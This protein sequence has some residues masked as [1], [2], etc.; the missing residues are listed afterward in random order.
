MAVLCGQVVFGRAVLASCEAGY[1]RV[2]RCMS[3]VTTKNTESWYKTK[4]DVKDQRRKPR[5]ATKEVSILRDPGVVSLHNL[6]GDKLCELLTENVVYADGP[7]V[8][9]NKPQGLPITG[10]PE[11]VSVSSLLPHLQHHLGIGSELHI[12]KAASK[13]S[14]GLVLLSTCHTTTQQ[15]E[16]FYAKCRKA[17]TPVTTYCAVTVGVPNPLEGEVKVAL[18]V[19]QIGDQRL[20]VPVIH[21]TQGELE[22]REVKRTETRYKVL[23]SADGCSLVQLQPMSVFQSQLLVHMTRLLCPVLGDHTYSSRVG[24]VLGQ[25]IYVPLE[26][27]VPRTQ[28]L[29]EKILRRMHFT[30]QQMH[31]M[32]LHLHL[33]QLLIPDKPDG[34]GSRLITAPPPPF[35]L[36]TLQ[37]LGLTME[38]KPVRNNDILCFPIAGKKPIA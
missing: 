10:S 28:L 29:E 12:V 24:R 30:Q 25:Y 15:F 8:A 5:F 6:T 1:R 23:D 35:Y 18:K 34:K 21:P 22:R 7:V 38:E 36:R 31:R 14:S 3:A 33:H 37:L 4:L 32:P 13:E 19:E 17:Q 27:A 16:D 20:V 26:N 11:G 9:I 2:S